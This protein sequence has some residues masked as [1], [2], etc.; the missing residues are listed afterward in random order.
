MSGTLRRLAV[1]STLVAAMSSVAAA[2]PGGEP[3]P[4]EP[5]PAL[6]PVPAPAGDVDQ[7]VLEDANSGRAWLA[8][9]ALTAPKG[10]V[11]FTD[12]ELILVGLTY[13]VTDR[14][15]I[16]V[17]T[18]VPMFKGQPFIGTLTAKGQVI[19][20]GRVRIAAHG[21]ITHISDGDGE[22]GTG[23]TVGGAATYCLDA[24]CHSLINGFVG[25]AFAITENSGNQYPIL[26]SGS[27]V[28]RLNKHVKLVG[29]IDTGFVPGEDFED[30]YLG[31]YGVRFTS[32]SIAG[33]V[34]FVRPFGPDF[35]DDNG[36]DEGEFLL[37]LPWI[38]FTY[39]A[40]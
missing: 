23:A 5:I 39:R 32:G 40:L 10:S 27:I 2:Q 16:G 36:D 33:D 21:T 37:G 25:T 18:M 22:A 20:S 1:A 31:W 17:G 15:Q 19:T 30:V 6:V 24:E 9:T 13:G 29:E 11:S 3:P 34:G 26:L 35:D 4:G 12:S 14:F 7:G 28:G 38:N 8:P